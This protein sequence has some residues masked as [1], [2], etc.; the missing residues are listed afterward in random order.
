M[1]KSSRTNIPATVKLRTE[2]HGRLEYTVGQDSKQPYHWFGFITL[3]YRD[4]DGVR[5]HAGS[6]THEAESY[7]ALMAALI[8]SKQWINN[9]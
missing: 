8:P 4:V 7:A 3:D 2:K 1:V 9:L 5:H 6:S